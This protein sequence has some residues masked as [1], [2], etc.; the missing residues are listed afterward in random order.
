[1]TYYILT[2]NGYLIRHR[3][4]NSPALAGVWNETF[5]WLAM[6]G[7]GI[8]LGRTHNHNVTKLVLLCIRKCNI[9]NDVF[10]VATVSWTNCNLST[11]SSSL[12]HNMNIPL[13]FS[14]TSGASITNT[15]SAHRLY[16]S[17]QKQSSCISC[18]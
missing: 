16:F 15:N 4:C 14:R 11:V 2:W 9:E 10:P 1:M 17:W 3:K 13:I 7:M 6:K 8:D 18:I 12:K 5:T